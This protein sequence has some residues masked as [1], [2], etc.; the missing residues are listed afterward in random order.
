MGYMTS[1]VL[2]DSNLQQETLDF[3]ESWDFGYGEGAIFDDEE[4]KWY[5]CDYDMLELSK[6]FPNE[7]F[8]LKG[9]GEEQGDLWINYYKNG[10]RQTCVAKITFDEFDENKLETPVDV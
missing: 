6:Q 7:L 8:I 2:D 1:F 9:S 5:E 4:R 10:K 3:L